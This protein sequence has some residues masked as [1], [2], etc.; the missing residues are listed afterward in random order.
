MKVNITINGQKISVE[1]NS[2]ILNAASL[3]KIEIPTLCNMND[4]EPFTSCMVCMV[5][6]NSSDRLIPACST[7]VEEG[8]DISTD[9]AEV[10][11]IRKAALALI[12]SEHLGDCEAQ[13]RMICPAFLDIPKMIRE[14]QNNQ[15]DS[16][17]QTVMEAIPIPKTISLICPAPCE[18]GCR[19]K[20][21]DAP[22]AIRYLEKYAAFNAKRN[23]FAKLA[24]SGRKIAIIGSGPTGLS[25]AWF[26]LKNGHNCIVFEQE[27]GIGG[28]LRKIPEQ[29]LP[30][31]ILDEEIA[32]IKDAGCEFRTNSKI[33][34]LSLSDLKKLKTNFDAI[35]L[36]TG[37]ENGTIPDNFEV[38]KWLFIGGAILIPIKQAVRSVA[39][40][41]SIAEDIELLFQ[42][43]IQ[44]KE[45]SK[46]CGK[47][48]KTKQTEIALKNPID[49]RFGPLKEGDIEEFLK[50]ASPYQ[51]FDTKNNH[52]ISEKSQ[53][54]KEAAR[55]LHCDCT[56]SS[57][58][59][60]RDLATE[61][62]AHQK[63]YSRNIKRTRKFTRNIDKHIIYESGKCIKCGICVRICA[64]FAEKQGMIFTGRSYN[65][66]VALPFDIPITKGMG[67]AKEECIKQCPTGALS[68][69]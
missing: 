65:T 61:Y 52:E 48:N 36:A 26:L 21:H 55:C 68:H 37:S 45:S 60:L 47:S 14:I 57:T 32:L 56:K 28:G 18:K 59:K 11:E 62:D 1:K 23:T 50:S 29:I 16:A 6:E 10:C 4:T 63:Q 7:R 67:K 13:C 39:D 17:L 8:M 46:L 3:L 43:N 9:S 19:R 20:Q 31:D 33:E 22:L 44:S 66:E 5:K 34:K 12:L 53:A 35:V 24:D 38:P 64:N 2:L 49:S 69:C 42:S 30:S 54:K 41:K 25:T 51:R 15:I 58:C 27:E 40:G